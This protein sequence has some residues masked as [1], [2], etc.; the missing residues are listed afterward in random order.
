MTRYTRTNTK[1]RSGAPV[2]L[3]QP[4]QFSSGLEAFGRYSSGERKPCWSR[5]AT[6]VQRS[7]SNGRPQASAG[8]RFPVLSDDRTRVRVGGTHGTIEQLYALLQAT[9]ARLLGPLRSTIPLV[10]PAA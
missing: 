5:C 4:L 3:W 7:C 10:A 6:G 8:V 1:V 9:W 2:G